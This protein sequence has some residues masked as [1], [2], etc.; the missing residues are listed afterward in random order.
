MVGEEDL[1][2]WK[3]ENIPCDPFELIQPVFV[4]ELFGE[5]L[6]GQVLEVLVGEGIQFVLETH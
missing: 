6:L 1:L 3:R 4:F 2:D 5:V